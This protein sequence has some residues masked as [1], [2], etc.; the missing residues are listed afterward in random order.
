[1]PIMT[2]AEKYILK[3]TAGDS[4]EISTQSTV[5]VNTSIPTTLTTP[6][7]SVRLHVRVA[8]YRGLPHSSPNTSPYFS[9]P[10]HRSD[11]YSLQFSFVFNEDVNGDDLVFGNDFDHPIR[12]RLPY[13]TQMAFNFAKKWVDPGLYGDFYADEPYLYGL[14]LSSVNVLRVGGL[15]GK[16]KT[17]REGKENT[18]ETEEVKED[19]EISDEEE[20]GILEEGGE[21]GGEEVRDIFE[22][23]RAAAKRMAHFLQEEKRKEFILEKGRRYECDFHNPYLDFNDFSLKLPVITIPI[24]GHWDGQP[25]RYVLKNRRTN[26]LYFVVNFGLIPVEEVKAQEKQP[27]STDKLREEKASASIGGDDDELD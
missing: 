10:A 1:L 9:H 21:N 26:T 2:T 17:R 11:R 7:L 24:M 18:V 27:G 6:H 5:L 14:L 15:E 4:Y 19:R 16:E 23:P 20:V 25:L 3:V 13:G 8:N 12:D 22:V